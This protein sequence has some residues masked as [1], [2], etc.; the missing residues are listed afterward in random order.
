MNNIFFLSIAKYLL[1]LP[2]S[3]LHFI[4]SA[5]VCNQKLVN[6]VPIDVKQKANSNEMKKEKTTALNR[7]L[8][9]NGNEAHKLNGKGEKK[10]RPCQLQREKNAVTQ[11]E[12][13]A[14]K[15][16]SLNFKLLG[17]SFNYTSIR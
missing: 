13:L 10:H 8:Q 11:E 6:E 15:S 16:I 14:T 17:F 3:H 5:L 12:Q 7:M 4:L 9:E 2:H 1:L